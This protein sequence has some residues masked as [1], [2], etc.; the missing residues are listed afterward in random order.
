MIKLIQACTELLEIK[1][2]VRIEFRDRIYKNSAG[3]HWAMV[4]DK[5]K[6][7]YH[8]IKAS[9]PQIADS[10]RNLETII[11]HE[12][13]HAWQAEYKPIKKKM[14]TITFARKAQYLQHSLKKLGFKLNPIYMPD[15]D[16]S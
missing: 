3:V 4:T 15:H 2:P 13:V 10:M 16:K 11:A 12:F 5:N 14:H 8:V 1:S 6:V 9:L 7:K